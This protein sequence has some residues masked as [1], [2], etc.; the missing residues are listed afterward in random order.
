MGARAS[1]CC[2][3]GLTRHHHALGPEPR[4]AEEQKITP[5]EGPGGPQWLGSLK[6]DKVGKSPES[7]LDSLVPWEMGVPRP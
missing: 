6:W 1:W 5:R 7:S 2:W 3:A 4:A